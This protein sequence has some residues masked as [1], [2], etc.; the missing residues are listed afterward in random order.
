MERLVRCAKPDSLTRSS[1]KSQMECGWVGRVTA[2][3]QEANSRVAEKQVVPGRWDTGLWNSDLWLNMAR[4]GLCF[5]SLGVGCKTL[6]TK[7]KCGRIRKTFSL[8]LTHKA[9]TMLGGA[10]IPVAEPCFSAVLLP[11]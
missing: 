3:W 4:Q 2:S 8:D 10:G 11:G 1:N 5:K 9:E 7:V 6:S